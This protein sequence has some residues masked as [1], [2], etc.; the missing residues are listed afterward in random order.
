MDSKTNNT[1]HQ[2]LARMGSRIAPY[3]HIKEEW[4]HKAQQP[5]SI[6]EISKAIKTSNNASAP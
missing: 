2:Q 3:P 6:T 5:F 4:F 1:R